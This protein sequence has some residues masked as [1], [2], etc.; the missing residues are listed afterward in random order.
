[1]RLLSST[2]RAKPPLHCNS[3]NFTSHTLPKVFPA[4][5]NAVFPDGFQLQQHL[6]G[7]LPYVTPETRVLSHSPTNPLGADWTSLRHCQ[8]TQLNPRLIFA[9]I[10]QHKLQVLPAN[11]SLERYAGY[12]DPQ[13]TH[14]LTTKSNIQVGSNAEHHPISVQPLDLSLGNTERDLHAVH[15]KSFRPDV[16]LKGCNFPQMC[17]LVA[18]CMCISTTH[19]PS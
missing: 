4:G 3:Y 18:H 7:V 17:F 10:L 15:T 2:F 14:V 1:M 16:L 5:N 19:N 9:V 11:T 8:N 6:K 13:G 12:V